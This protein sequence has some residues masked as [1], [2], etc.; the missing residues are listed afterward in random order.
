MSRECCGMLYIV[1]VKYFFSFFPPVR[2]VK[3]ILP[4]GLAHAGTLC[5][6]NIVYLL[7]NVGF[8]QMLKSFTPVIIMITG[9]QDILDTNHS[10]LIE[11]YFIAFLGYLAGIEHLKHS[12]MVSVAVI[13]IGTAA[14]CSFSPD[15]SL[16]GNRYSNDFFFLAG[17]LQSV[18][19]VLIYSSDRTI[20]LFTCPLT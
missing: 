1:S 15:L 18:L 7:L 12:V 17:R 8:I 4:Y 5:F 6:G 2:R 10:L 9:F 20:F 11:Y 13:S 19:T 14:T 3:R 16:L